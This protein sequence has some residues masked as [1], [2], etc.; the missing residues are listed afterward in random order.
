MK[1]KQLDEKKSDTYRKMKNELEERE[2]EA[3]KRVLDPN[4]G[5]ESEFNLNRIRNENEKIAQDIMQKPIKRNPIRS[6][7]SNEYL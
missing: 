7:K 2:K 4:F 3:K 6:E 1:R 5:K